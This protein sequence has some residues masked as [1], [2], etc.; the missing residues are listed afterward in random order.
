MKTIE[1]AEARRLVAEGATLP[2]AE[3]MKLQQQRLREL[4]NYAKANSPYFAE[5]YANIG[6]DFKLTDLPVTH[7]VTLMEHF[8][9]WVT[10]R[11]LT[12]EMVE[13]YVDLYATLRLR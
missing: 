13:E 8:N 3:R 5:L 1:L 7:K 12:R 2:H 9:D 10:D 6:D 11:R 4:V